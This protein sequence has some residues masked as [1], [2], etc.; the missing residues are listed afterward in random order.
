MNE[1]HDLF[2]ADHRQRCRKCWRDCQTIRIPSPAECALLERIADA[3]VMP[4]NWIGAE[5]PDA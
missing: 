1:A 2:D 4:Y 5:E 3:F